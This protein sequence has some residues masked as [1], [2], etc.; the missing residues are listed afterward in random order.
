MASDVVCIGGGEAESLNP[1]A[2][3]AKDKLAPLSEELFDLYGSRLTGTPL[4]VRGD[5][6]PCAERRVLFV[7]GRMILNKPFEK[8]L[9]VP[10]GHNKSVLRGVAIRRRREGIDRRIVAKIR[11]E[12]VGLQFANYIIV[13]AG[14]AK[15]Y[16]A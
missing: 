13:R 5:E 4:E 9:A 14:D 16:S 11:E 12:L 15:C 8:D 10:W 2:F 1:S 3:S 6:V 7:E